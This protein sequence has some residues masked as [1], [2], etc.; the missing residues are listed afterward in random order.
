MT[1]SPECL[2]IPAL[3]SVSCFA[4]SPVVIGGNLEGQGRAG[5]D[6][7]RAVKRPSAADLTVVSFRDTGRETRNATRKEH[8]Q[9]DA[10]RR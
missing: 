5:V 10:V 4:G 7:G 6:E 8:G 1:D 3:R 9:Q 2:H